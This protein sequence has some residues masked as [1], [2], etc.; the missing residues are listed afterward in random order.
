MV[1]DPPAAAP[2]APAGN[3]LEGLTEQQIAIAQQL[4]QATGMNAQFSV[5]CAGGNQWDYERALANFTEIRGTIPAEAF[6]Q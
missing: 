2:A 6:Q 3:P 4:S 5:L 1:I